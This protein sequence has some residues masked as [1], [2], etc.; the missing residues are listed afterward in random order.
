MLGKHVSNVVFIY[1]IRNIV[2]TVWAYVEMHE[3]VS[4]S[5]EVQNLFLYSWHNVNSQ[6]PTPLLNK[7][8]R[9]LLI[10]RN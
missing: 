1:S 7:R 9:M 4:I 6:S 3:N 2:I 10:M 5:L 8:P